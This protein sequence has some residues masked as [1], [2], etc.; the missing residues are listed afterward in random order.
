MRYYFKPN[1][2][3]TQSLPALAD[4]AGEAPPGHHSATGFALLNRY[5]ALSRNI[6]VPLLLCLHPILFFLSP[7]LQA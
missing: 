5:W 6:R 4:L 2:I 3:D 1:Q 7:T